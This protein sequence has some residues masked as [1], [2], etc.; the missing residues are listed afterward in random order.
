MLCHQLK[1]FLLPS[2]PLILHPPTQKHNGVHQIPNMRIRV[3]LSIEIWWR[4]DIVVGVT[5]SVSSFETLRLCPP[6][7]VLV[8]VAL[9]SLPLPLSTCLFLSIFLLLLPFSLLNH[10]HI[11]S[12]HP[13]RI[14]IRQ[15]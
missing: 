15:E 5:R 2:L 9:L 4:L 1:L 10:E 3:P 7:L 13:A 12:F 8:V 6:L 11:G 14:S